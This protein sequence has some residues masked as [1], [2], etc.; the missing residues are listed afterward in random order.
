MC[1][2]WDRPGPGRDILTDTQ[3]LFIR[4]GVR[5]SDFRPFQLKAAGS[6]HFKA[7]MEKVGCQMRVDILGIQVDALSMEECVNRIVRAVEA[8]SYLRVVTANPEM[9]YAAE[10]NPS[11]RTVMNSAGLITA[12]GVGVVWAARRLG[13]PVPERVT[14]IDLLQ[15]L[16]P[17]AGRRRWRIYFLGSRPGVAEEAARKVEAN[18]P[19]IVWAAAHG[20]FRP[21]EEANLM[22]QIRHFQPDLFLVG[23]GAP[24]QEF[25]LAEH[26]HLAAVCIGVGG[27]F[28]ALAGVV[29]RAPAW[30]QNLRLEWLYRLGKEP[31]RWRRQAILPR[32]VLRVLRQKT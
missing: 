5:G 28:D 27:S 2:S 17:V 25:W 30:L 15:M 7:L 24:R 8:H 4:P 19:G 21:E 22:E 29:Q 13:T 10:Q 32:F 11:L 1:S 31:W 23:L 3:L 12:D 20:Y 14:G 6:K 18:S 26:P 9:I 16:F